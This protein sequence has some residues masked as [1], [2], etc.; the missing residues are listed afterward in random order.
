MVVEGIGV[1]AVGGSVEVKGV[2]V[3]VS[4]AERLVVAEVDEDG[5]HAARP[6]AMI[7][8]ASHQLFR[9]NRNARSLPTLQAYCGIA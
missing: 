9:R 4:C 2:E 7:G 3:V 8:I 5:E 1:V 6:A